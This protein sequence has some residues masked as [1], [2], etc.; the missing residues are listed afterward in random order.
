MMG[1]R[2]SSSTSST[3]GR[4]IGELAL[5]ATQSALLHQ[6][7][8]GYLMSSA[9]QRR[10]REAHFVAIVTPAIKHLRW[11]MARLSRETDARPGAS[12]MTTPAPTDGLGPWLRYLCR[13]CGLIYDEGEGDPD[14]GIAP[15]TRFSDIPDDWVC[16]V[17]GVGKSDFEPYAPRARAPAPSLVAPR[18]REPGVVIVGAG[19]AGWGVAEAIRALDAIAAITLVTACSG[20]RY[21]KPELSVAFARGQ[22]VETL[23]RETGPKAAERLGVRLLA[24]TSAVGLS[25]ESRRLRTT[26]GTLPFQALVLA[27]GAR[28]AL[29]AHLPPELCWRVNDLAA[30]GEIRQALSAGPSR[31]AVI[32][33][34]LVGCEL[35][36]D[37]ARGGHAVT[38]L[39]RTALPLADVLPEQACRRVAAGLVGVGVLLRNGVAVASLR[40][41]PGGAVAVE[42]ESGER[43]EADAIVSATGLATD[44]RLARSAG[45]AFDR[46]VVVDRATLRTSAPAVYATGDC[47][48]I[49]GAPCRFVEPLAAQAEAIAH[50][51][52][53]RPHGGYDHARPVLRLK[54]RSTPVVVHGAPI[55]GAEWTVIED[56][57]ERL[58]M[59]QWADGALVARL[60]A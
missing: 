7:A 47:V 37:L 55:A 19:I 27:Q 31:V 15:G 46:G 35:S 33:S 16:P 58:M 17:C 13:A 49:D 10:I 34:G 6:G 59:E 43:L 56:T 54:T 25:P 50:A 9:P 21:H 48:S 44:G 4:E 52:L 39:G 3:H 41:L 28:P 23:R 18:S 30:W 14:G 53:G 38:L 36:E 11:E 22:S 20:D 5:R 8:R 51:I 26:R 24:T 29:P 42:L 1:R 2:I 40:S 57:V 32:G 12:P 60:A 45:L